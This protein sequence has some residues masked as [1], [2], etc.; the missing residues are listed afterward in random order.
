M[1][2]KFLLF[3][4]PL[5]ICLGENIN[6][7]KLTSDERK[8]AY[9]VLVSKNRL[10]NDENLK[11]LIEKNMGE[12][13]KNNRKILMNMGVINC[14]YS[15]NEAQKNKIEN[16]L[17]NNQTDLIDWQTNENKELLNLE[18]WNNKTFPKEYNKEKDEIND[19]IEK[20]FFPHLKGKKLTIR[21]I[22]G[23]LKSK[24]REFYYEYKKFIFSFLILFVGILLLL[25]SRK[26]KK[27]NKEI[28]KK[29]NKE[30]TEE[31]NKNKEKDK[32]NKEKKDK[33]TD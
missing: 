22:D 26:R 21:I 30:K 2:F 13:N 15:I 20:I 6:Y 12:Y 18:K 4:F 16:I 29:D 23:S 25:I 5:I 9:C 31:N 32:K 7:S 24:I 3:I 14:I 27:V 33:K 28:D 19:K 11:N 8:I 10:K 1:N 17:I